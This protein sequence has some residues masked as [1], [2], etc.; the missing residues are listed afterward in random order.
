[1]LEFERGARHRHDHVVQR[2]PTAAVEWQGDDSGAGQGVDGRPR[3]TR[4]R[5][6]VPVPDQDGR[7][8]RP[9]HC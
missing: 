5:R 4:G 8:Q 7:R 6:H 1:M 2:R 9:G 3:A